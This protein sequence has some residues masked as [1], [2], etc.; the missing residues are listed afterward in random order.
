MTKLE[1]SIELVMKAIK[2][3]NTR[4]ETLQQLKKANKKLEKML[5]YE[6]YLKGIS[7]K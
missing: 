2:E 3:S 1:Q 7:C 5:A 6:K 4:L